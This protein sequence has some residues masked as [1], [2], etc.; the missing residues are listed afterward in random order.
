MDA[1]EITK[2]AHAK[3]IA[4][5]FVAARMNALALADFPGP[6]PPS[7]AA[8]YQVQ[9]EAIKLWPDTVV[10]W[11]IGKIGEDIQAKYGSHRLGGPIFSRAVQHSDGSAPVEVGLFVGG[12]AAVEAEYIFEVAHDAPA[13]KTEWTIPE[14]AELAGRLLVGIE[15]A[16]SPL[17][18]INDLGPYVIISDFGNNA[19]EIVGGEIKGWRDMKWDDLTVATSFDGEKVGDGTASN[20]PGSPLESL[21]FIAGNV[22]S[23]GLPLKKGMLIS[24][25]AATGVHQIKIGQR[26]KVEFKGYGSFD[27]ITKPRTVETR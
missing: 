25:G 6:L 24:T 2:F 11:K 19:D 27:V 3:K 14:A 5:R 21:Q 26:A 4:Q 13:D 23:R 9:D 7:L 16:G 8:A 17:A 20:I 12:F 22:A 18:T 15:M 10:G 1:A